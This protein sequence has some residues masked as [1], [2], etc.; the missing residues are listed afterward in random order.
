LRPTDG[1]LD[2]RRNASDIDAFEDWH[3]RAIKEANMAAALANPAFKLI[4]P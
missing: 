1:L 3:S 2:D 4:G